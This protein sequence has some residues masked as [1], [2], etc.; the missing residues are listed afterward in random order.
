MSGEMSK[1]DALRDA[2]SAAAPDVGVIDASA[3]D[4]ELY[5]DFT[6]A[7]AAAKRLDRRCVV[8]FRDG[9]A[10]SPYHAGS[11]QTFIAR[12]AMRAA[13]ESRVVAILRKSAPVEDAA[14]AAAFFADAP[15]TT[16]QI[17]DLG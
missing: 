9:P 3:F 14:R 2:I 16:G 7:E 1:D 15:S 4:Q 5:W 6:A 17:L 8:F 13:P 11:F 10:P 12:M